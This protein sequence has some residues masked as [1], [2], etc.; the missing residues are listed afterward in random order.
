MPRHRKIKELTMTQSQPETARLEHV[1][2]TV[3]DPEAT[4]VRLCRLFGWQSRWQG[5][6]KHAGRTIHVGSTD[7]YIA[8]Y[9]GRRFYF[10]DPDWI[11][12]EVVSYTRRH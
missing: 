3:S 11:E 5:S 2:L 1:N 6:A 10:H 9:S 4:A 12:Y 7:Q 8:L